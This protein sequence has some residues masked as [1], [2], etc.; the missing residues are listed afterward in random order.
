MPRLFSQIKRVVTMFNFARH[1]L[2][3]KHNFY[4]I[5]DGDKIYMKILGSKIFNPLICL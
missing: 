4:V 2:K 5:L 1:V 3:I